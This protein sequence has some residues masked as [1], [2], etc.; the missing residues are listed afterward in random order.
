MTRVTVLIYQI[1]GER[2]VIFIDLKIFVIIIIFMRSLI[3][4][5]SVVIL[6]P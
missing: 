5:L 6:Q 3:A 2:N 4:Y 1:W